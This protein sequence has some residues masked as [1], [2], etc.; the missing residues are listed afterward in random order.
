MARTPGSTVGSY[1]ITAGTLSAGPNYSLSVMP[2]TFT[3]TPAPLAV[4][5]R[6]QT[7]TYGDADP[8]LA[9][10]VSG[11]V[12]G[13]TEASALQGSLARDSG[14]TVGSYAITQ[15]S[16]T[17]A[18]YTISFTGGTL[19]IRPA[20]L[21]AV[22]GQ[23]RKIYGDADPAFPFTLTGLK[24]GDGVAA[25][26]TGSV[27][28]T[29]GESVGSYAISQGTLAATSNYTLSFTP[30]TLTIDPAPLTV[31]AAAQGRV[32]GDADPRLAYTI[33][34]LKRSDTE[35]SVLTGALVRA[36]GENAG[37]YAITQGSLATNAN[38]SLVFTGSTFTI[39]PAPLSVTLPTLSKVYG[40]TDPQIA[41]TATGLRRGDTQ[42]AVLTG[43][44]TR[45][46][47]ENAGTYAITQGSLA[48]NPN[49]T[50]SF[51]GGMLTINPAILA[52]ATT[53]ATKTYGDTD[54]QFTFTATGFRRGDTAALLS[55]ALDRAPGENAGTYAIAQGTLSAGPNY[56]VTFIG[57]EFQIRPA[58]LA[59][60]V[61]AASKI[62]GEADPVF[63][64]ALTG[65]RNG[66]TAAT[67]LSGAVARA[68]GEDVGRYEINQGTLAASPNYILGFTGNALTVTP[69]P[70][71]IG[72]ANA[73]RFYGATNPTFQLVLSGLAPRDTVA[74]L[75]PIVVTTSASAA[76]PVG[77]Y[78]LNASGGSNSNYAIMYAPGALSVRPAP[79]TITADDVSR[80]YG[81][82]NPGFTARYEGLVAGD[83]PEVVSGLTLT[84]TATPASDAG[85]YA[86]TASGAAA[87]N[88]VI[89]VR[90]GRLSVTPAPLT[91]A[92]PRLERPQ[93]QPN[94]A[95]T[96]TYTGFVNGDGPDVV[97][98]LQTATDAEAA[99]PPGTYT[100]AL[101]GA[102][103]RNYVITLVNGS[104]TVTQTRLPSAVA[105][106]APVSAITAVLASSPPPSPVA[107]T[108]QVFSDTSSAAAPAA[109]LPALP[110]GGAATQAIAAKTVAQAITPA[111]SATP[112]SG[113][114]PTG[115]SG[116]SATVPATGAGA[117]GSGGTS[118]A[119]S[120]SSASKSGGNASSS[121][122][123]GQEGGTTGDG[124]VGPSSTA[125]ASQAGA[126]STSA[127]VA[128]ARA[129]QSTNTAAGAVT[130]PTALGSSPAPQSL[131]LAA[132][133]AVQAA[134][135]GQAAGDDG[136]SSQEVIPGLLNSQ[137]TVPR[138]EPKGTPGIEKNFPI[139]G[140]GW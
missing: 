19:T 78:G 10:T 86:I 105:D 81:A 17:A 136:S 70:L 112:A 98:G 39:N 106:V 9:Y 67:A 52:V 124:T 133:D 64:L 110:A 91:I 132:A 88:Y 82:A 55:G 120:T 63:D 28:R 60:A 115:S 40:D 41:F 138:A 104:V 34:G 31:T 20:A 92:G 119:R 65:L 118:L 114:G 111:P 8:L 62:Y 18:N 30:G 139:L 99:A 109:V 72:V 71:T 14:R 96:A 97:S 135:S 122:G 125:A 69:R 75:G 90:P 73:E 76:S 93:G 27:A 53:A 47:G 89:T 95:F 79:L 26:V 123:A 45:A 3:I 12:N 54:P 21:T 102:S 103:A 58:A 29:P 43:A 42:T 117:A 56:T 100:I 6:T 83:A 4:A 61:A 68:A 49:Y 107:A 127:Q 37:A 33:A 11:L 24:H 126:Q 7:I 87:A 51:T 2:G 38:Y 36:P 5:A 50:L 66:D 23:A 13:D 80:L 74:A 121:Q 32:Y 85:V 15:G 94:P 101:S 77:T 131:A 130:P 59:A 35:A 129:A 137:S 108:P 128:G 113:A 84:T 134:A 1:A 22:V 48:A 16:L 46:P 57:A 25:A 44:P 140:R 116:A